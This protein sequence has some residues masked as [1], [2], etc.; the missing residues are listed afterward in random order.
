MF[1]SKVRSYLIYGANRKNNETYPNRETGFG[2]LN[3]KNTFEFIGGVYRLESGSR[4]E[5]NRQQI[6]VVMDKGIYDTFE[7]RGDLFS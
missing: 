7:K 3:I 5:N 2:Y 4:Q 6:I 1:S